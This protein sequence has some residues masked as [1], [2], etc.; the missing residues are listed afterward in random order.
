MSRI[1]VQLAIF[2]LKGSTTDD[3]LGHAHNARLFAYCLCFVD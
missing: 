2:E 3:G 1:Q